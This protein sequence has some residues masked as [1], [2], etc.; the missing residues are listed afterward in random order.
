MDG[1][2]GVVLAAGRGDRL[3]PLTRLRPKALCPVGN[4]PLVDLALER[5][6]PAVEEVAVNLHHGRRTLDAHLADDVHRSVEPD[7]L[8]G[9]AGALGLLRPWIS[10]R[11]TLVVNADAWCPGGLAGFAEGWDGERIRLL[12]PGSDALHPDSA[13]AGALM[14]WSDVSGLEPEPSGLY[15]ASWR[16]AAQEGRVDVVRHDGPFVDCG[17]PSDYL[18]A[19]LQAS[20]GESVV[21]PGAVVE[22]ELDRCVVWSD[23]R[24]DAGELLSCCIRARGRVTVLAR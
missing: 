18:A 4:V 7:R 23:A 10:G 17:T 5:V 22:G 13:I 6:R 15:E 21:E 12:V 19:N 11:G 16:Q 24:V 1:V 2:V 3:R 8:L 20:G 9:T 14:P